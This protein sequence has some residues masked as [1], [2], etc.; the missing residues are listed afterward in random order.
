MLCIAVKRARDAVSVSAFR[1]LLALAPTRSK[2][3]S[4]RCTTV[5]WHRWKMRNLF[6]ALRYEGS[7]GIAI[8]PIHRSC[9]RAPL[10]LLTGLGSITEPAN[11]GLCWVI[12]LVTSTRSNVREIVICQKVVLLFLLVCYPP[13]TLWPYGTVRMSN[14]INCFEPYQIKCMHKLCCCV[15]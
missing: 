6:I 10:G 5:V 7:S 14:W 9:G 12:F 11:A 8:H 15:N 3:I 4:S 1:C 13:K 2:R